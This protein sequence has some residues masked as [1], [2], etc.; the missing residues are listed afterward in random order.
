MQG[1]GWWDNDPVK[2]TGD[3]IGLGENDDYVAAL[4]FMFE[5][6]TTVGFGDLRP[7]TT[8]ERVYI[9]AVMFIGASAFGYILGCVAADFGLKGERFD[10]IKNYCERKGLGI[11]LTR[12]LNKNED[13]VGKFKPSHVSEAE[14]LSE[15]PS[16]LR[17]RV[18]LLIFDAPL[19]TLR[20]FRWRHKYKDCFTS[21]VC[22]LLQP[23]V[24]PQ[25]DP[26]YIL[27]QQEPFN[28]FNVFS[29]AC[30]AVD[31]NGEVQLIF[32][33]GAIFGLECM[34]DLT[35]QLTE[36]ASKFLALKAGTKKAWNTIVGLTANKG[37]ARALDIPGLENA[38]DEEGIGGALDIPG[39]ENVNGGG[40]AAVAETTEQDEDEVSPMESSL[41]VHGASQGGKALKRTAS[42]AHIN[43]MI[44]GSNEDKGS[45]DRGKIFQVTILLGGAAR[46]RCWKTVV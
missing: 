11:M 15:L 43:R 14:L 8:T 10:A 30:E 18:I 3:N 33:K 38:G 45:A 20:L 22:G 4:W 17:E 32:S 24:V 36:K 25:G 42:V 27:G 46:A 19:T 5:S 6:L 41:Q 39:L 21:Y 29:G 16:R 26:I 12:K 2:K 35:G 34:V 9:I 23:M 28:I 13:F 31:D 7:G 37:L 40:M 1:Y 44:Q